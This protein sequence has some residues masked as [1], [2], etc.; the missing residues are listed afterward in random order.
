MELLSAFTVKS[1]CSESYSDRVGLI[2]TLIVEVP[3]VSG[4]KAVI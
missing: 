4:L 1:C 2:P 3:P